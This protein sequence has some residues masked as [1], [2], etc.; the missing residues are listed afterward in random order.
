[1]NG[2]K[3]SFVSVAKGLSGLT[4]G[5]LKNNLTKGLQSNVKAGLKNPMGAVA[6]L[7]GNIP[8]PIQQATSPFGKLAN[9][10]ATKDASERLAAQ[11]RFGID[12]S[13]PAVAPEPGSVKA[14]IYNYMA[15]NGASRLIIAIVILSLFV[16]A[17]IVIVIVLIYVMVRLMRRSLRLIMKKQYAS[18]FTQ[19]IFGFLGM[20]LVI[21]AVIFSPVS[22]AASFTEEIGQ[23]VESLL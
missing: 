17:Y 10:V 19:G 2:G 16:I 11:A 13:P 12:P 20:I 15:E 9:I 5:K 7:Q 21:S 14:G 18:G 6:G 3:P 8:N 23:F 4:K 22:I 1:M